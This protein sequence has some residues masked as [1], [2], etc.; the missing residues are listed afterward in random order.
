MTKEEIKI[1]GE[2]FA[3]ISQKTY[4]ELGSEY[5]LE[6]DKKLELEKKFSSDLSI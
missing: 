3:R 2:I 4:E 1:L 6:K 5:K